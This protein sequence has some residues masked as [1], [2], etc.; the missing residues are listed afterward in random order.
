MIE[1][2]C[3]NIGYIIVMVINILFNKVGIGY[4]IVFGVNI[5]VVWIIIYW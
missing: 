4:K 5:L 2:L 3:W 1:V